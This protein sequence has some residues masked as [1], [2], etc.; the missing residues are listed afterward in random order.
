MNPIY[1]VLF[2]IAMFALG[3]G[4]GVWSSRRQAAID[5]KIRRDAAQKAAR[6]AR[7]SARQSQ[8]SGVLA[9]PA[10][11]SQ[12]SARQPQAFGRRKFQS[13]A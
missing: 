10:P 5:A 13:A 7:H 12:A 4:G 2:I 6:K 8:K 11:E 1:G 9:L 3:V